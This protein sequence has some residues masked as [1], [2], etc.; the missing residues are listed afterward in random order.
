MANT[1]AGPGSETVYTWEEIKK[2]TTR[3][4]GVWVVINDHV[5]DVSSFMLEHPGGDD[6]LLEVA[7]RDATADFTE[8]GHSSATIPLMAKCLIG[9]APK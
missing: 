4:S 6:T 3:E 9:K 8:I 5:Y 2:H 7:G 1:V